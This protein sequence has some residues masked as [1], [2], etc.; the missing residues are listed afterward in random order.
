MLGEGEKDGRH[1][2]EV[3]CAD[4]GGGLLL[5]CCGVELPGCSGSPCTRGFYPPLVIADGGG[6]GSCRGSVPQRHRPLHC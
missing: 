6:W 3:G 1:G 2:R 4:A 5:S